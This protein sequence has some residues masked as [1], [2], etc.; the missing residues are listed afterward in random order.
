MVIFVAGVCVYA[1]WPR[2][3]NQPILTNGTTSTASSNIPTLTG[4]ASIPS[5]WLTYRNDKF[6][7]DFSYPPQATICD[8]PQQYGENAL[9]LAISI[10]GN[11]NAVNEYGGNIADIGIN[12]GPAVKSG[13]KNLV[14]DFYT[15]FGVIDKSLN[16]DLG[17]VDVDGLTGYGGVVRRA[18]TSTLEYIIDIN[19][20]GHFLVIW[21][22]HYDA[23]KED[24][25]L[26]INSLHL[27]P[28]IY[29]PAQ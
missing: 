16:P 4:N 24:T 15:G 5:N 2:V 6:S 14:N 17:Y 18:G 8:I 27:D 25:N 7:F 26:I 1:Y 11:C 20:G 29:N 22:R 3:A 10:G 13:D 19:Q 28:Q 12:I 21:D 9:T 23:H